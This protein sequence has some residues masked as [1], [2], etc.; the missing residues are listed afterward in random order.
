MDPDPHSDPA[1][2][3]TAILADADQDPDPQP[4]KLTTVDVKLK[5]MR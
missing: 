1:T 3:V 5:S 2:Q 4:G